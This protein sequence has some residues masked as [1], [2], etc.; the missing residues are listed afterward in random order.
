MGERRTPA[1]KGDNA[2]QKLDSKNVAVDSGNVALDSKNVGDIKGTFTVPAYQR[3]YRW[4]KTQVKELLEDIYRSGDKGL[5]LQP[6]VVKRRD[7]GRYELID[8]QQRLTTLYQ[9]PDRK[10]VV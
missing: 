2:L 9:L 4:D 1:H 6:I 10:S 7:D 3:G 8:G 5:Y